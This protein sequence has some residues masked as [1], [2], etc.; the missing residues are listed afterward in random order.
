VFAVEAERHVTAFCSILISALLVG[1]GGPD[2][3][4]L[5]DGSQ[6]VISD[7]GLVTATVSLSKPEPVRGT[8]EF[9]LG[10][11]PDT[12]AVEV[13]GASAS[14]Q[15]T[16]QESVGTVDAESTPVAVSLALP[17]YG[18]WQVLVPLSVD[19]SADALSFNL[20]VN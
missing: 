17:A 2:Y 1:C 10:F 9:W 19:G 11:E 13:L 8:N 18:R 4:S 15:A 7:A 20:D 6:E 14:L 5:P 16:D 3:A 12:A